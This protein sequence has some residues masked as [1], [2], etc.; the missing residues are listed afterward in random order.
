M[1]TH[2]K[3]SKFLHSKFRQ[4]H[5]DSSS[6]FFDQGNPNTKLNYTN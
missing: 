5:S 1:K 3:K 4:K 2:G 6:L